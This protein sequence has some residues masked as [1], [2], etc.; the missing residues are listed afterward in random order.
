VEGAAGGRRA[1]TWKVGSGKWAWARRALPVCAVCVQL[2]V[3][4][5]G[6]AMRRVRRGKARARQGNLP[7]RR[8]VVFMRENGKVRRAVDLYLPGPGRGWAKNLVAEGI[9]LRRLWAPSAFACCGR[10]QCCDPQ[11]SVGVCAP[12]RRAHALMRIFPREAG[13]AAYLA[14][15]WLEHLRLEGPCSFVSGRSATRPISCATHHLYVF[16]SSR[17]T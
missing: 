7:E 17:F 8:R 1:R 4:C 16:S 3:G 14:Q 2:C 13:L 12:F 6:S 10:L 15:G 11:R 5:E 9:V